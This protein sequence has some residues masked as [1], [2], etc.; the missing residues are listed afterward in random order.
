MSNE[1]LMMVITFLA[2]VVQT[3]TGLGFGMIVAPILLTLY[4][5][6]DA[7]QITAVLT[8][9]ISMSVIPINL[10]RIRFKEL[11]FLSTG[12]AVGLI[13]GSLVL[14][15][16]PI[17]SIRIAALGILV[18]ALYSYTRSHFDKY[19]THPTGASQ[20]LNLSGSVS[21]GFGSGLMGATLAMP[22]PMAL[23]YLRK[24]RIIPED[25]KATV[26][27]LMVGS[28]SFVILLSIG[29]N[30]ISENAIWGVVICTGSTVI[31]LIAGIYLSNFLSD[32]LFDVLTTAMM[33]ISILT[34]GVKTLEHYF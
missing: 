12:S 23:I 13:A 28:Y 19:R 3:S 27:A 7:I 25:V 15:L 16:A 30:G 9:L 11:R 14:K 20:N 4:Q 17:N 5:P 26:F 24:K 21:Y 22:G 1:V 2:A 18:Y 29:L 8:L 10:K 32:V 34:L 31:G 6:I 33:C